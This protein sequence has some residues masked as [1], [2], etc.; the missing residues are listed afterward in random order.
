M[1]CR[2]DPYAK[3]FS[4]EYYDT[5]Q[6]HTI[7]KEAIRSAANA[8]RFGLILGTLGRQGNPKVLNVCPHGTCSS[9]ARL[10]GVRATAL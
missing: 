5:D 3:E 8:R 2:Y 6:M 7:R 10:V 4:R 1:R 9:E